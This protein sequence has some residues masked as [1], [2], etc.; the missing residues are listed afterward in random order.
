MNNN[1]IP[2]INL[3][4][5]QKL[6]NKTKK[7]INHPKDIIEI[8]HGAMLGNAMALFEN[9][10]TSIYFKQCGK[11]KE[12]L[13]YLHKYFSDRGY[14][15]PK[16]PIIKEYNNHRS[17]ITGENYN[18]IHFFSSNYSSFNF[19]YNKFYRHNEN[20]IKFK[21]IPLIIETYLSPLCLSILIMDKGNM[22][23][24][25]LILNFN[26]YTIEEIQFFGKILYSKYNIGWSINQHSLNQ[27]RLY[28]NPESTKQLM[29]IV[30][31][32]MHLSMYDKF[33]LTKFSF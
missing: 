2:I 3:E 7:L 29:K 12:Y 19:I 24:N 16:I 11:N 28:I 33:N 13:L 6:K 20:N 18:Y 5:F 14:C 27:Y 10:K 30:F 32:F 22:N 4:E 21:I 17:K 31:P 9:N 8:I 1:N 23:G 15:N 26:A 25:S